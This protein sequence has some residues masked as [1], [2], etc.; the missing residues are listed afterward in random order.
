MIS[1]SQHNTGI[2]AID[3]DVEILPIMRTNDASTLITDS[4]GT[5]IRATYK[6]M[7][8]YSSDS[9]SY[10]YFPEGIYVEQFDSL[11]QVSEFVKADTAYY[12]DRKGLW[13]LVNNV[14]IKNITEG[15]TCET[16]EMFWNSNEPSNSMQA[17]YTDKFVKI[18]EPT[19][20]TTAIGLKSNQSMTKWTLYNNSF[21]AEIDE[22][23]STEE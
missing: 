5:I 2:T 21:D 13:R 19:R 20:I 12:F 6:V 7:D 17:F 4:G 22:T 3:V 9:V 11:F 15:N 1:C 8:V 10:L 14:L 18:T 23:N 16:S